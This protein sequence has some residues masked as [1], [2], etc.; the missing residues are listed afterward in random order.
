MIILGYFY[1]IH[2]THLLK[3]YFHIFPAHTIQ[4]NTIE[5]TEQNTIEIK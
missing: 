5:Q 1:L 3:I 2:C 4:Y